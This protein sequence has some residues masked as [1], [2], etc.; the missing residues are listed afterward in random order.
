MTSAITIRAERADDAA[1]ITSVVQ[2]AYARVAHSDH[3]EHLMIARL[4]QTDA[5]LPMLSLLAEVAG[6]P[7]GHILLTRAHIRDGDAQV[8]TLAL[9]PLSVIPGYQRRGIGRGLIEAAHAQASMLGFGTIVL[10]GIPGYYPRFGY[11]PLS[12]YRITLPFSAPDD[13]CMI[14]PLRPGA[15]AGV[16]GVVEYA[17]GWLS[18]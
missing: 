7:A 3:R 14:L 9:A 2:R 12:R 17:P 4:R 15:L 6:Q 13:T 11:E 16:T 18:H 8:E 1:T 5:F 10:V